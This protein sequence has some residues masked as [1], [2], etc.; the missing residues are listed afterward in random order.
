MARAVGT[1]MDTIEICMLLDVQNLIL[2]PDLMRCQ[3]F[4]AVVRVRIA[5][6]TTV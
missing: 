3:Q 6:E 1:S 2:D 4:D 5:R